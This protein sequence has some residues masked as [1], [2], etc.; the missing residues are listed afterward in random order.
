MNE[1]EERI[2]EEEVV[3]SLRALLYGD[4]L[5]DTLLDGCR[6]SPYSDAGYLTYDNGFVIHMPDGSV[7]Q[8]TVRQER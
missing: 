5:E 6:T 8:I 3:D 1:N 7:F 2:T 4:S